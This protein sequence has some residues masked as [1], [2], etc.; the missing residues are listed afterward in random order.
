MEMETPAS[1][2]SIVPLRKLDSIVI[3]KSIAGM[4]PEDYRTHASKSYLTKGQDS[5][6]KG[7]EIMSVLQYSMAKIFSA[8]SREAEEID[9]QANYLMGKKE[10]FDA[11][12]DVKYSLFQDTLDELKQGKI[13][14]SLHNFQTCL[15]LNGCRDETLE[16]MIYFYMAEAYLNAPEK[17]FP[18][19]YTKA[20]KY[21][22]IAETLVEENFSSRIADF[23]QDK[24]MREFN[25]NSVRFNHSAI[26]F[27]KEIM[28]MVEEDPT[29]IKAYQMFTQFQLNTKNWSSPSAKMCYEKLVLKQFELTNVNTYS[30]PFYFKSDQL[31]AFEVVDHHLIKKQLEITRELIKFEKEKSGETSSLMSLYQDNNRK[32]VAVYDS[33]K[34]AN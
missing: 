7:H 16:G 34:L 31:E 17:L 3:G 25:N 11:T 5:Q 22:N 10:N 21:F 18:E 33:M 23:Y 29:N 28:D 27:Y 24:A 14:T 13:I 30:A 4:N 8:D 2:D 9:K 20:E 1:L 19:K 15:Y 26:K 6:S 32:L 12:S